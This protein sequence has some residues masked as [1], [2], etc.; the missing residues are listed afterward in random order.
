MK[1]VSHV[2]D[3]LGLVSNEKISLSAGGL[4]RVKACEG[5]RAGTASNN[6][7]EEEEDTEKEIFSAPMISPKISD[8]DD[9]NLAYLK[10]LAEAKPLEENEKTQKS[11]SNDFSNDLEQKDPK[12]PQKEELQKDRQFQ[13][14]LEQWDEQRGLGLAP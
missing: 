5:L 13:E 9:P 12:C 6:E 8:D 11:L 14:I 4:E 2:S 3:S 7:L 10:R 1:D